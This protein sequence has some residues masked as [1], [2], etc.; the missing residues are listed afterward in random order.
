MMFLIMR[1]RP[2][3]YHQKIKLR[4]GK[5]SLRN[6]TNLKQKLVEKMFK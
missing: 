5:I 6:K 2:M 3:D 1:L 4:N